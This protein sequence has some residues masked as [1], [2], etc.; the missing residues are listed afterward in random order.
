MVFEDVEHA[1]VGR[2]HQVFDSDRTPGGIVPSLLGYRGIRD[3]NFIHPANVISS[4][5]AGKFGNQIAITIIFETGGNAGGGDDRGET[6]LGIEVLGVGHAA[7][8]ARN[9]IAVGVVEPVPS[10]TKGCRTRRN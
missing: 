8:S 5:S 2:V 4:N 1:A 6:I 7:F 3:F 10:V 9:H